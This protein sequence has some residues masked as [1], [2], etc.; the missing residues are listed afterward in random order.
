MAR[1]D[2]KRGLLTTKL[3][4][5]K[6][7]REQGQSI[8]RVCP[9]RRVVTHVTSRWGAP[10]L[11]CLLEESPQR[12]GELRRRLVV[13]SEKVLAQSLQLLEEDGFVRREAHPEVPPRV[14]YSLTPMGREVAERVEALVD[15]AEENLPRIHEAR[16]RHARAS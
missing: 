12:F 6:K 14:E 11:V 2:K 1:D 7:K 16:E 15:W 10:L 4:V 5:A 9:S 3:A 8:P 13:V